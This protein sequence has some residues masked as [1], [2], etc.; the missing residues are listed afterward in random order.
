MIIIQV[1]M[2][3]KGQKRSIW[4]SQGIPPSRTCGNRPIRMVSVAAYTRQGTA[5]PAC[6]IH[7]KA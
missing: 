2:S 3:T 5:A 1:Q 6:I 7:S 4:L